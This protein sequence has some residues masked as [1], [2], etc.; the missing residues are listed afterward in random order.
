MAQLKAAFEW[1]GL[2]SVKTYINSG[3]VIFRDNAYTPSQLVSLLEQTIEDEFG[4]AV[5]VLVRDINEIR[6]VVNA[7][8]ESW[9]N[10]AMMKCDVM[11]LWEDIDNENILN[12]LVI[13]PEIDT[14]RYIPGTVLFAVDRQNVTKSG[15]LKL[16]GTPLYKKMTIRN[17]NTTR[18]LFEIMKSM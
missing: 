15:L 3:N 9:H 13:K 17:C 18:K 11:F 7:L 8:P 16:I 12:E 5:K 10:D 14:V 4:F 1:A 2:E 6:A